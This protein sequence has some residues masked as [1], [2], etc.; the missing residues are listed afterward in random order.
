MLIAVHY[1]LFVP[2]IYFACWQYMYVH[3]IQL[4]FGL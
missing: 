3:C 1:Y 4:C 2:A